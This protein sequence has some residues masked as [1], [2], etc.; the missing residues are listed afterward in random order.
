MIT[1]VEGILE[2]VLPT[3]I[4]VQ[5]GGIGYQILIPL[6]SFDKMPLLG[7]T[8]RILTHHHI[9]E[10]AH[11]LYG[12]LSEAERDLFRLLITRI[13]G[14]GPKLALAVL[15][16]MSLDQF[17]NAVVC[18]DVVALSKVPGV[19]KKTAERIILELKDKLGVAAQW[20]AVSLQK[21]Q[22]GTEKNLYDAI[23]ALISL[24]YKQSEADREVRKIM[25]LCGKE[26]STEELVRE[27]LK[28]L[29]G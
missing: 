1:F 2:T 7:S 28:N 22:G 25:A 10:D 12:F 24:G 20:E 3:M 21:T 6:S 5:V 19:G 14:V 15:S 13:S 16:G 4:V 23:L 26:S 8:L 11:V 29:V 27:A 18:S 17:K 9:R